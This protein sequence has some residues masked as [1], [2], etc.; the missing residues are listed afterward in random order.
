MG[1]GKY[2]PLDLEAPLRSTPDGVLDDFDTLM[3]S[4]KE[5]DRFRHLLATETLARVCEEFFVP[6]IDREVKRVGFIRAYM[7]GEPFLSYLEKTYEVVNAEN[8][9]DK[10]EDEE[11]FVKTFSNSLVSGPTT[12][13]R[14]VSAMQNSSLLSERVARYH[15]HL[16]Q[17]GQ[18][19]ARAQVA[20]ALSG[21]DS[22]QLLDR[23]CSEPLAAAVREL[24]EEEPAFAKQ[25]DPFQLNMLLQ[26]AM[27]LDSTFNERELFP[28]RDI[29]ALFASEL[30]G[31]FFPIA[32]RVY[33]DNEAAKPAKKR[34]PFLKSFLSHWKDGFSQYIA[35]GLDRS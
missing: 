11:N 1:R 6:D 27:I 25:I 33:T 14:F 17:N 10:K 34:D 13:G 26:R 4:Q 29:Q 35:E 20:E 32:I 12:F 15:L 22:D 30:V 2:A 23:L 28:V 18:A 5:T 21:E 16:R 3:H 31:C 24:L 19:A 9:F 7:T 8:L